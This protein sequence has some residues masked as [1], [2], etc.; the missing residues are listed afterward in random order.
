[1]RPNVDVQVGGSFT[2]QLAAG[3][4]NTQVALNINVGDAAG[5]TLALLDRAL[6]I[7]RIAPPIDARPTDFPDLLGRDADVAAAG[8]TVR[9]RAAADTEALARE[10][11]WPSTW[12][13][14]PVA[15]AARVRDP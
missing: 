9:S 8:R 4:D 6:G 11:A 1:M 14:S 7:E 12:L 13:C 5:D 15:I 3:S 2:G 10:R